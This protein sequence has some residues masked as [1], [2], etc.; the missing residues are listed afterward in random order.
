MTNETALR[1]AIPASPAV[2]FDD[3]Q[4]TKHLSDIERDVIDDLIR[5][6]LARGARIS[7]FDGEE[8]AISRSVNYRRITSEIAATDMTRLTL[9][10]PDETGALRKIGSILLIHGN[11]AEVVSDYTDHPEVA[12]I[13]MMA[14]YLGWCRAHKLDAR[15]SPLD[16]LSGCEALGWENLA[17]DLQFFIDRWMESVEGVK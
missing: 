17:Y 7:V 5:E 10:K 12:R 8:V 4:Y 2:E 15:T 1:A 11:D 13:V 3:P 16:Q 14:E 6:A 9:R